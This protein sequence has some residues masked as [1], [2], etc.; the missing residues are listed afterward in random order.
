MKKK[1]NDFRTEKYLR[2]GIRKY[3]FGVASVAISAG[4]MFLG[5]GAVSAMELQ[6]ADTTLVSTSTLNTES[7]TETEK[8]ETSIEKEKEVALKTVDKT[9]LVKKI[10]ELE[11]KVKT[12]KNIDDV[13]LTSA[14]E[15]L[16]SAKSVISKEIVEQEEVDTELAKIKE[17]ITVFAES[18][19][20]GKITESTEKAEETKE[21]KKAEETKETKEAEETVKPVQEAKKVLEQVTSEAKVTNVLAT[22]A[23]RKNKLEAENKAAIEAA[24]ANNKEVIAEAKKVLVTDSVTA[25]QGNEQLSRLNESILAVYNELKKAGIGKDGNF[26]VALAA[27]DFYAEEGSNT[28]HAS[29][30]NASNHTGKDTYTI[31]VQ[32][33]KLIKGTDATGL[34]IEVY[35]NQRTGEDTNAGNGMHTDKGGTAGHNNKGRVDYPLTP[36]AAKKL[37]EEA[38]LWKGKLRADGSTISTNNTSVYSANGGYEYLATE[39][40]GYGYEQGVD[41]VYIKGLKDRI[42]VTEKAKQAGWSLTSVTPTNLVPGVA[43]DEATDTIQGKVIAGIENGVYDLRFNITATNTDGRTV[44]FQIQNLRA[45][46][47]GWQDST[48]PTIFFFE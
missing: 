12:A 25:R 23:I 5:N 41:R 28:T 45:G 20:V 36:D 42:A 46:W 19:E 30:T 17:L 32:E 7:S 24:I 33:I 39:I 21:T 6:E 44:T 38:P 14:K 29:E 31:P 8:P 1:Q 37:A 27:Q 48:P 10:T 43:Y 22:E 2:Y 3:S 34:E 35:S 16:D 13:V 15:L 9:D 4:L 11:E 26:G 47:V 40:Y 18:V